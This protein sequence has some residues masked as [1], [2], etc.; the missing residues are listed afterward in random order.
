MCWV[1]GWY[2][3]IDYTKASSCLYGKVKTRYRKGY[4]NIMTWKLMYYT[5]D[6]SKLTYEEKREAVM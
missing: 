5:V 3:L 2:K 4:S 1:W 6:P